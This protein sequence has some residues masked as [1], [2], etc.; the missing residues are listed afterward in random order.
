MSPKHTR[1][2]IDKTKENKQYE[3]QRRAPLL[4]RWA[5]A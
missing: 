2:E 4:G 1:R 3:K 5:M